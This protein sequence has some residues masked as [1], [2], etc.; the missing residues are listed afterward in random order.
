MQEVCLLPWVENLTAYG[1]ATK[2]AEFTL[3][4]QLLQSHDLEG[5]KEGSTKDLEQRMLE[6]SYHVIKEVQPLIQW[7]P[8]GTHWL[9]WKS[10]TESEHLNANPG[11]GDAN[12]YDE[13]LRDADFYKE[14]LGDACFQEKVLEHASS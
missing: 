14:S 7:S 3:A 1:L 9:E 5:N 6:L 10:M 12:S 8:S 11:L 13:V 4:S 2:G